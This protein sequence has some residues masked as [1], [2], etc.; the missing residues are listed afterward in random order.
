MNINRAIIAPIF[1]SDGKI[2]TNV[3]R[4]TLRC[5]D[6]FT[7]RITRKILKARIPVATGPISMLLPARLNINPKSVPIT[8]M[9]S[10]IF[11]FD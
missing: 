3:S 1:A 5:F 8:M 9:K 10:N 4:I 7:K 2:Y 11:H 6:L